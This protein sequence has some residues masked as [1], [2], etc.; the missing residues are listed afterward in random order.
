MHRRPQRPRQEGPAHLRGRQA[1]AMP[2]PSVLDHPALA[3][4]LLDQDGVVARRQL[5]RHGATPN[6][7]AR[8]LRRRE[9][10]RAH[11]GVYVAHNGPL[12]PRQREWVA[13]LAAWPAALDGASALSLRSGSSTVQVAV[14]HH[15]A[16][17]LPPGVRLR[18][19]A[20][21]EGR[22]AWNRMPPRLRPEEALLDEMV[23]RL[24]RGE[25]DR[26]FAVLAEVVTSGRTTAERVL[27]RLGHRSRI[28]HR[29]MVEAMLTDVRDGVCSVLER[30]YR[31]Q[32]ERP[33]GL[34]RAVRQRVSRAT[35]GLTLQD[36]HY[37]GLGL[38]VE[39]DGTLGHTSATDR[40]ADAFRDLCEL[41]GSQQLTAR[42]TYGLV[43]RRSCRTAHLVAELLRRHGWRGRIRRCPRCP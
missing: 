12:T 42:A 37:E 25:V 33:H 11:P 29:S 1:A 8:S 14:A 4:T 32:V 16:L 40:D 36:V 26:A 5:L 17:V 27:D 2:P 30:G 13:I 41:A 10:T 39:L 35:G 24:V 6:D 38:V 31:D 18:R 9:L 28:A 21:L 3:R 7:V 20:D 34:P 15:R 23:S 43:F 19:V 22:A